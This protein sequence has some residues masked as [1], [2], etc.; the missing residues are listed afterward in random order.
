MKKPH[1]STHHGVVLEDPYFWLRDPKYPTVDDPEILAHLQ[2]E[3]AWFTQHMAPLQPHVDGI[4]EELK[5]RLVLDEASV[6]QRDGAWIYWRGFP[7][8]QQYRCLY[9]KPAPAV[10]AGAAAGTTLDD[11]MSWKE[12][13]STAELLLDENAEASGKEYF[14]LGA[15]SVSPNGRYLAWSVDTNGSERFLLR[16]KD[17]STGTVLQEAIPD[18]MGAV[19]WSSDSSQFFYGVLNANWR[20]DTIKRHQ[21][22]QDAATSDTVVMRELDQGFTIHVDKTHSRRFILLRVGDNVTSEIYLIPAD[23]PHAAP[24]LVKARN[25][26][27]EYSVEE[28]QGNLF[29]RVND[30][31]SNFRVV[32]AS[33]SAPGDWQQE[34]IS[35]SKDFYIRDFLCFA[36]FAVVT[37]RFQGLNRVLWARYKDGDDGA[38]VGAGGVDGGGDGADVRSLSLH[39]EQQ[40]ATGGAA[41]TAAAISDAARLHNIDFPEPNC[42]ASVPWSENPEY[43]SRTLRIHY[44]S[45]ITPSTVFDYPVFTGPLRTL[46]VQAIP[47]GYDKS[48]FATE[49]HVITA[50]DGAL[51]PVSVVY[52]KDSFVKDGQGFMHVY[53]YGAYG[54]SIPPSFS[55]SRLSLLNRGMAYAIAHI[56]GGD[57]MGY[58][59]YLDGKLTKRTNTFNDFVD[60]TRGLVG[61]GYAKPG[62]VSASGGSAGGELMG[63]VVNQAP[64][65]FGAVVAHVPFVDVV[66]TMLDDSLPLTPG[67][68]PEWGNPITDKAAF[69]L[70]L[71]YSPYDNVRAQAYPP[72][73][74]TAGLNDPRVTYWEPAKWVAKLRE[75]KTDT[76][77]V[78]LKT[79]MGAGHG[80]KSGRFASLLETAEEQV[81]ILWQ[82]GLVHS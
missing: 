24:L 29:V 48:Q 37:G 51:V 41:P 80:G 32:R 47:S 25:P 74:V 63:A 66:N 17:L 52:K 7:L 27:V 30:T 35:P 19:V 60:V 72:M 20:V 34:W 14:R 61:L 59:W 53:A 12:D 56:R 18:T 75:V 33:L 77:V 31:H 42:V 68:F 21:L 79:N 62:H 65:L 8:G 57:D 13:L 73:L 6:P 45:M 3:N 36:D 44:E 1:A 23:Q 26:G 55:T 78:L 49:R 50:R 58:Q 38:G 82:L 69:D 40:G 70:L 4:F 54:Y 81:F 71:S 39:Q 2:A 5:G 9:R 67:E 43:E 76:R 46:K 10:G 64:E 15:Q 11:P 16:V 22:G 28:H